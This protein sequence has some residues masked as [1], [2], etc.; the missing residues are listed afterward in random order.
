MNDP[1]STALVSVRSSY[2]GPRGT[3]T[4]ARTHEI[5][6]ASGWSFDSKEPFPTSIEVFLAAV[7]ADILGTFG[8]LSRHRRLIID[9]AEAVLTATLADPLVY[10]AVVGAEGTPRLS[11]L[12]VR[13]HVGTP[14]SPALVRLAWTDALQRAPLLNTLRPTVAL[15]VH[16]DFTD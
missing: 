6:R 3:V 11:H 13:A 9:E 2:D 7:A 12:I 14:S 5:A 10:L 15:E 1:L 16:L 4:R 8:R